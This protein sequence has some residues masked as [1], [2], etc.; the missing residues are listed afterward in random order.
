VRF[1]VIFLATTTLAAGA[2]KAAT[3]RTLKLNWVERP[4]PDYGYPAMTL[5]AVSV[6]FQGKNWSLRASVANRSTHSI[7]VTRG[8]PVRGDYRFGLILPRPEG[9]KVCPITA[10]CLP[11]LL[12]ARRS[13]PSFPSSL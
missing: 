10:T 2:A 4:S 5:T 3:E 9:S 8:S 6:T 11:H 1:V 13:V 12:D 7:S